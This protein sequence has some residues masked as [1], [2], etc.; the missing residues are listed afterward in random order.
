MTTF[1]LTG[2]AKSAGVVALASV[3]TLAAAPA[4]AQEGGWTH[5]GANAAST[6]YSPLDQID[7][8]NF[9]DLEVAWVW[10]GDNFGP[11]VYNIMRSTPIYAVLTKGMPPIGIG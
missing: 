1:D 2:L 11:H 5:W 6:R 4:L 3:V 10:R 9:E 7:A 8:S